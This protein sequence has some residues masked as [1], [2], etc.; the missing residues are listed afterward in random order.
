MSQEELEAKVAA[1]KAKVEELERKAKPPAPLKFDAGPRGPTTTEIAINRLG[2]S[3]EV[4]A[5][6]ARTVPTGTVREIV[7]D[8][9]APTLASAT[10]KPTVAPVSAQNTS[11]WREAT[12]LGNPPGI[13]H[14]DR[15]CEAADA[16]DRAELIA[17]EAKRLA[18]TK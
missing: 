11:G 18:Q 14:V 16:K 2:M 5:E 13:N 6:F 7:N 12:P 15:L 9:R 10:T 8:G 4:H 3:P 17:Q 1:L